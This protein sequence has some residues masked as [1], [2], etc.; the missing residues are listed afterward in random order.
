MERTRSLNSDF[1]VKA[2]LHPT[3]QYQEESIFCPD[4]AGNE[5]KDEESCFLVPTSAFSCSEGSSSLGTEHSKVNSRVNGR[6]ALKCSANRRPK[7]LSSVAKLQTMLHGHPLKGCEQKFYRCLIK[8]DSI[9]LML[10]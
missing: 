6:R 1:L 8:L 7:R 9:T 10:I 4:P 2:A 3:L 5:R